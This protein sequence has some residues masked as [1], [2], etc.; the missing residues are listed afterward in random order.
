M[1]R[2]SPELVRNMLKQWARSA[3]YDR[4]VFRQAFLEEA[5]R[6]LP[7]RVSRPE[8]RYFARLVWRSLEWENPQS[9]WWEELGGDI[10]TPYLRI[11]AEFDW[12]LPDGLSEADVDQELLRHTLSVWQE[13]IPYRLTVSKA[14]A[15]MQRVARLADAGVEP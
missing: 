14:L 3:H 1:V 6:Q 8:F 10:R 4:A 13:R 15:L 11:E 12:S 2:S 7:E 5:R 9:D